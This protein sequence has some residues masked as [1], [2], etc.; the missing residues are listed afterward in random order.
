MKNPRI[1][2]KSGSCAL[3]CLLLNDKCWAANVGDSRLLSID[4]NNNLAQ[5]TNDH[6]P[7][8]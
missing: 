1:A 4:K 6:K 8:N 5:I 7:E 2:F 3:I